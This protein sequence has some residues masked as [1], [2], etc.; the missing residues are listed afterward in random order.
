MRGRSAALPHGVPGAA[1]ANFACALQGFSQLS[2]A[3]AAAWERGVVHLPA[4]GAGG[5]C[6]DRVLG[7][8]RQAV[9]DRRPGAMVFSATKGMASTVIHRWSTGASSP[10]MRRSRGNWPEFGANGKE[11]IS[12]R[13]VLRH[14]AGLSQ[15]NGVRKEA[16]LDHLRM[17]QRLAGAPVNRLL[18]GRPAYHALTYGWLLSGLARAVTGRGMGRRSPRCTSPA[19]SDRCTSRE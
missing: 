4:R 7:P 10:T 3:A 17:E 9:L 19:C 18:H 14:R 12:V 8:S 5:R 2:P 16:L 13:D 6:V 1:D 11:G 15:L